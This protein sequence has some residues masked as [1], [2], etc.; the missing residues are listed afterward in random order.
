[1]RQTLEI[2]EL[3]DRADANGAA[4]ATLLRERGLT[5]VEVE[6]IDGPGGHTDFL[7]I[8]IPGAGSS[9]T[10]GIIGRLGGVGARPDRIGL[11]SDADGAIVALACA[12]KLADM[13]AA[14][15]T[16]P[17]PVVIT[18]HVC[19]A[20]PTIPHEP[21]DLMYSPVDVQQLITLEVDP[22]ME[23]IVSV[24]ATK[25]ND[26]VNFKGIE[27]ITPTVKEGYV[28]RVAPGLAKLLAAVTGLLPRVVPIT[29]Q[30]ITPH[31]NG[32]YHI[33]SMMQP[34]TRTTAPVVGLAT[35]ANPRCLGPRMAR[36]T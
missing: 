28:L 21:V 24:D 20:A 35:V 1:M 12:L 26:I 31:G 3:L 2:Y 4:V 11:V 29:T 5:D 34:S 25:A 16:L 33:N 13:Q 18:T 6:G 22:R 7:R 19:P 8:Y 23:A 36:A 15:D 10:I 32:I 14:G 30:D 27:A 9:R 17:G